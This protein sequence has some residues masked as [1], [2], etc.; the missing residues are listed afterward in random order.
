[1]ARTRIAE[2]TA[3]GALTCERSRHLVRRLNH[4]TGFVTTLER[5]DD[6][7]P[8][9]FARYRHVQRVVYVTRLLARLWNANVSRAERLAWLHDLNRW[10]F[11]HNGEAGRF[12]QA[13]DMRRFLC[14]LR[15][16]GERMEPEDFDDL[17]LFHLKRIDEMTQ[18]GRCVLLGDMLAGLV[19]DPLM[20]VVGLNIDPSFI[21]EWIRV[22][23]GWEEIPE[24]LEMPVLCLEMRNPTLDSSL[25]DRFNV[26]FQ[27]SVTRVLESVDRDPPAELALATYQ[28]ARAVKEDFLRPHVFPVNNELVCHASWIRHQL[29]VPFLS[30]DPEGAS[31]RLLELGEQELLAAAVSELHLSIN[32]VDLAYPEIDFVQSQKPEMAYVTR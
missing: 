23:L 21:P 14:E 17:R 5:H 20:A 29:I 9:F 28:A 6:T 22:R 16:A 8:R 4:I 13:D 15:T 19:E 2:L 7:R 12:N 11:A 3:D 27:H 24:L 18:A 25:I 32:E 30:R 10:P 26:M 31:K 1:M